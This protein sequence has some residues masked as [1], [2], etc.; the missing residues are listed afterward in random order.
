MVKLDSHFVERRANQN[1]MYI[2]VGT[3]K[4][5]GRKIRINF[6][7]VKLYY[8]YEKGTRLVFTNEEVLDITQLVSYVDS[9]VKK[10]DLGKFKE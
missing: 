5:S 10:L 1:N 3:S 2:I 6:Q 4:D 8:E 9:S 7:H